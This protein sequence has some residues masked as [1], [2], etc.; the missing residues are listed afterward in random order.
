MIKELL[1]I[2]ISRKRIL[3]FVAIALC[4][5]SFIAQKIV[6]KKYAS[7]N[8]K[9][10][11]EL[12]IQ[13]KEKDFN[14]LLIDTSFLSKLSHQTNSN[15][16]SSYSN[17]P[18]GL[19]LYN[20]YNNSSLSLKAWSNNKFSISDK[21]KDIND[22]SYFINYENGF[23][24]IVRRNISTEQGSFIL[25]AVIP[26]K[27]QYFISNK[28]LIPKFDGFEEYFKYYQLQQEPNAYPIKSIYGYTLSYLDKTQQGEI[29]IY[30]WYIILLRVLG[31]ICF[32]IFINNFCTD[33]KEKLGIKIAWCFLFVL[34][35]VLRGLNYFV[36][37]FPF[38]SKK[39]EL[40]DP[41]IYASNFIH[42]SL[43]DLFV[44]QILFFW[45]VT[46]YKNNTTRKKKINR[47]QFIA[48]I[49]TLTTAT[50][51][52]TSILKS[53]VIDSK[54]SFDVSNFFSLNIYSGVAFITISLLFIN[55]Y[56]IAQIF[57]PAITESK[58]NY[59]IQISIVVFASIPCYLLLQNNFT[60][61]EWL[62]LA[63]LF[64]VFIFIFLQQIEYKKNKSI[65]H[66][67][68]TISL[69]WILFFT[70]SASSIIIYFTAK[71]ELEQRKKVAE[72]IYLQ[73]DATAENLLN[74][75][76][77]NFK[78]NFFIDNI[79]RFKDEKNAKF[80]KDSLI[81]ENFSGYLNKFLSNI[82]LF[83]KSNES[84]NN[85]DTLSC[86]AIEEIISKSEMVL[87]EKDLF[88]LQSSGNSKI[89]FY[90]NQILDTINKESYKLFISFQEKK[91]R[92][93]SIFPVL[94]KPWQDDD[95]I[96]NYAYAIYY[97]NKLVDQSSN[98]NFSFFQKNISKKY[99]LNN[100]GNKSSL[101][102]Q[103]NQH[104]IIILVKSTR[105]AL[106]FITFFAYLFLSF[107]LIVFIFILVQKLIIAKFNIKKLI[108]SIQLNIRAQIRAII[109]FVSL[110][111]FI[112]IVIVTIIFFIDKYN[113]SSQERLVKSVN[114][115]ST[116]IVNLYKSDSSYL[117]DKH[118][119][120]FTQLSEQL[121]IDM[122][123]F[124]SSGILKFSTQPYIYNK[125]LID[126]KMN[127][128]AFQKIYFESE[129]L[130]QQNE[131]IG[132]LS[133]ISL[134]KPLIDKNGKVIAC[135]NVPFLNVEADLKYE[136]SSF[137]LT[138]MNFNAFVF[139]IATA[140]AYLIA[141]RITASFKLITDKMKEVN[142]QEKN[143]E[144]V[145]NKNDE[146][147]SL[148]DEY[149]VMVRKLD[150]TAQAF[151]LSQKEVAWK[152]M[153]KQVAHEIKNPLTPMKLSLQYL[154]KCIEKNDANVIELSK[155]VSK[156]LIEQIDQLTNIAQDFSQFAN[157]GNNQFERL[158]L[159]EIIESVV[160]LFKLDD[161]VEIKHKVINKDIYINNDKIQISRL[162]TNIIKNAVEAGKE[163]NQISILINYEIENTEV[164]V[165][166]QDNGMG[167]SETNYSKM[168]AP[169]FTTKSS[170]T[171][172]GLAICKGI[173]DN[174]N[175]KIWFETSDDGTI[176]FIELPTIS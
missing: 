70:L 152:E 30:T 109:I 49:A 124:D 112:I 156:T 28:Y 126:T 88:T 31:L 175:G 148:V 113:Q 104:Q 8:V 37:G 107:S 94:F 72:K 4:F 17:K 146:I 64:W 43:G 24:E 89:Y 57:I 125:K 75:A 143:E 27:W 9:K 97:N 86:K 6:T 42:P 116:E 51:I 136:I 61:F 58:S 87:G 20:L 68:I 79:D 56:K 139:L 67:K 93:K 73:S 123:L 14:Q 165:S 127:A 59:F 53:L 128:V 135:I 144:I 41:S 142:W 90:K 65:V 5:S 115:I 71:L 2:L 21:D 35:S 91:E 162:F 96:N 33:I 157:I 12:K 16:L 62:Y 52:V 10:A 131:N 154:Q 122:N 168:F 46:F 138:L 77:S 99:E 105:Y 22:S 25:V 153:A 38:D 3:F 106:D 82:Y 40:F 132:G 32:L 60:S 163:N 147:G 134:Y 85:V 29:V 13:S 133:F 18:Y 108:S 23:F 101:I 11:I 39:L 84:I 118:E 110:F 44:N 15:F 63:I 100:E 120:Q 81:A 114:N 47:F 117:K 161:H 171:G 7:E 45:L 121:G 166:I 111:S 170:G 78:N 164:L 92:G 155:S 140:I 19:F 172:L 176:F 69:K 55:F 95:I 151:A 167:I 26:I 50:F 76:T 137:I 149:N 36:S 173:V 169:N 74:I 141:N 158:N 150:E 34:I 98:Y 102:Y 48:S 103:P 54:I 66:S 160:Q 119:K 159:V 129:L 145:W 80:L 1:H 174:S 130:Y 83:D